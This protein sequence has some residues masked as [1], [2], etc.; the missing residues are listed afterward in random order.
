MLTEIPFGTK[1]LLFRCPMPFSEYDL[2]GSVLED[3]K[4]NLVTTVVVLAE[5]NEIRQKTGIDLFKLYAEHGISVIH[6]PIKDFGIP[7]RDEFNSVIKIVIDRM[8]TGENIA[9]HCSA[10]IGR[11][12]LFLVELAKKVK[13]MSG[14]EALD[15]VRMYVP[16]AVES[17]DQTDFVLRD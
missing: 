10:G 15:W 6:L 14:Q 9:A 16:C 12:G 2:D 4:S 13:G 11:T 8:R 17:P 5:Y 7:E 3:M 1:G